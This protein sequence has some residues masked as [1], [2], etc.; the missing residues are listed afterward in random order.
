MN[1]T[2]LK[3]SDLFCRSDILK[4][5]GEFDERGLSQDCVSEDFWFP[6]R[7]FRDFSAAQEVIHVVRT[8]LAV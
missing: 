2:A 6:P 1:N 4:T 5:E 7:Y 8:C 3:Q